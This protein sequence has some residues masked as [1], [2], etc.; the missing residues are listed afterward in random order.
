MTKNFFKKIV[1]SISWAYVKALQR[2]N[3]LI[4]VAV[5]GSVGKTSTKTAIAKVLSQKYKV[6]WQQGN[7]NDIVSVPLVFFGLRMP[8]LLNP[9]S[10]LVVFTRMSSAIKHYPYEVVVLELGT[11]APGQ[12]AE[13]GKFLK[14]DIGVVTPIAPEH[15]EFF[16]SLTEV[17][18]EELSIS[19]YA[20]K[21]IIYD[22]TKINFKDYV[23][24]AMK[25]Y[26]QLSNSDAVV[27]LEPGGVV[28]KTSLGSYRTKTSLV[29]SHQLENL[30]VACLVGEVLGL[31]KKQIVDGLGSVGPTPGRMQRL[32][33]KNDSII[34]DDTYNSSPKALESALKTLEDFNREKKIA[35]LGNMN[36]LGK[37]SAGAHKKA[38][39][40]IKPEKINLLITIGDD[41][42]QYLASEA[43]KN[44]CLVIREKSPYAIGTILAQEIDS[45]TVVLLKGSQNGV[46]LEEAIKPILANQTDADKLVRQSKDWLA[47]K[48]K[49]FS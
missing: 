10:W 16:D 41:A 49:M 9:L 4:V 48:R 35:V 2:K 1:V 5:V 37:A 26:G 28:I 36:E 33:G 7:Y 42:N 15:M 17:A 38:G 3:A 8:S 21:I 29:G 6:M 13:F 44:G 46:F 20:E 43:E 31:D 23:G 27:L 24:G 11:D 45:Q 22:Q 25:S 34:L 40:L 39:G 30:G 18:K 47:K 32:V 12:I 19:E 14:V